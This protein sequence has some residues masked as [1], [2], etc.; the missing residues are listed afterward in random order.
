MIRNHI[1]RK[2]I[3]PDDGQMAF[4]AF[5]AQDIDLVHPSGL[6]VRAWDLARRFNRP[7]AYDAYYLAVAEAAACSL[8][9]ADARLYRA[10]HDPLNWVQLLGQP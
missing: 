1:F 4:E 10:V 7:A 3:E 5:L 8:W 9:T 6:E 2:D